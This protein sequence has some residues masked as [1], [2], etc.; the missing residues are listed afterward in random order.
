M[1]MTENELRQQVVAQAKRWLGRKES[2]GSHKVIIDIYNQIR[3]L[4]SGYKMKYTDPWCAAFVSAVGAALGLTATILPECACDRMIALYRKIGRWHTI[5]YDAI[6]RPGDLIF[7]DWDKN[8][9]ADHVGIIVEVNSSGYRVI[10]GNKSDSVC[11]RTVMSNYNLIRGFCLPDYA[12]AAAD[13]DI[14]IETGNE[15]P[16]PEKPQET[17]GDT[18]TL[19]FR[20]LRKGCTGEDV[21]AL[22]RNLKSLGFDVGRYG[23]DGDFGSD[24]RKAVKDYQKSVRLAPDGEVGPLTMASLNGL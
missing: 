9:T 6:I 8:G 16:E 22:Q 10:E 14:V 23:L 4:P 19:K 15:T 21:R 2:D 11:Y 3:P 20:Y 1:S 13:E 12:A 17:S 5:D 18:Y 24:T 7:Y